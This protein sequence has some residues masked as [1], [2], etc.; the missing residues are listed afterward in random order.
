[1]QIATKV[2][3]NTTTCRTVILRDSI[4]A[5]LLVRAVGHAFSTTQAH[6]MFNNMRF[7]VKE[8]LILGGYVGKENTE[9]S[10]HRS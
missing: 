7:M 3:A 5:R 10:P 6:T 4:C 2:I 8:K 9:G 1:M